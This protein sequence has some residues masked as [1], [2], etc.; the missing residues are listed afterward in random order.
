MTSEKL[1]IYSIIGSL[2]VA[3]ITVI[4]NVIATIIVKRKE[5]Q[6][7]LYK[8]VLEC[9]I[10]DYEFN[11]NLARDIASKSS[12][13]VKLVPAIEFLAFHISFIDVYSKKHIKERHVLRAL[14]NHKEFLDAYYRNKN[15]YKVERNL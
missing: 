12:T 6:Q 15:D 5:F 11:T 3:V 8:T 1:A 9:S 2:T 10:K 14:K 4:G 7:S 13:S